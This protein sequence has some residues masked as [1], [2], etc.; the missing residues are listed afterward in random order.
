MR[1]RTTPAPKREAE[2]RWVSGRKKR[3]PLFLSTQFNLT[4]ASFSPSPF[5]SASAL[6][7][8]ETRSNFEPSATP[9]AEWASARLIC[10]AEDCGDYPLIKGALVVLALDAAWF[11]WGQVA[12]K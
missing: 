4:L 7:F 9:R 5:A 3:P 8:A 12:G 2:A 1:Y 10:G 6:F 11:V